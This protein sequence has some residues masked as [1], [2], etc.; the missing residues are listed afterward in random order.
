[1]E[2]KIVYGHAA[3]QAQLTGQFENNSFAHSYLFFGPAGV[4]KYLVATQFA[5]RILNDNRSDFFELDLVE[6]NSIEKLRQFLSIISARPVNG[7]WKV[8]VLNNFD[9]ASIAMGNALLKT[10]EE[11]SP[12][13]IIILISSR[14]LL[15]TI[16]S[17]CQVISFNRLSLADM[18]KF[19]GDAKLT[20][21]E[22]VLAI[23]AGSPSRL[24]QLADNDSMSQ[25]ITSWA[26]RLANVLNS[27]VSEKLLMVSELGGEE[28]ASLNEILLA[29]L[30]QQ[31]SQLSEHPEFA[32]SMRKTM[33]ALDLLRFN[34]NKKLVLQRLL[35]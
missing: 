26:K 13:T 20:V 11:P 23:A 29:Y 35:L 4:G 5:G 15:P 14:Q 1:M 2:T 16:V 9:L 10:L 3:A 30:E 17:R 34:L 12:S 31:R 19:A 32:N 8:A 27:S 28:T 33:E 6:Q 7:E 22:G 25:K 18:E 21:P 24:I